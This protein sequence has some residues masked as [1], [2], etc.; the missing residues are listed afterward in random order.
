MVCHLTAIN[1][2]KD[3][4]DFTFATSV[5]S[6]QRVHDG[7]KKFCRIHVYQSTNLLKSGKWLGLLTIILA[8]QC[9]R[10]VQKIEKLLPQIT[11]RTVFIQQFCFGF[12]NL[13]I[14]I[15]QG[16]IL[17]L[18]VC[19]DRYSLIHKLCILVARFSKIKRHS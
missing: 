7:L 14:L 15:H 10:I 18:P 5:T 16:L 8:K 11:C 6:L 1:T 3:T 12:W 4:E 17:C 19:E 2:F 9:L 13:L